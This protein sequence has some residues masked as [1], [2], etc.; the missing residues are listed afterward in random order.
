LP[1]KYASGDAGNPAKG[2]KFC[3]LAAVLYGAPDADLQNQCKAFLR[4]LTA[5][6]LL[7]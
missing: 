4:W 1:L 5:A 2:G 7:P 3:K 6:P